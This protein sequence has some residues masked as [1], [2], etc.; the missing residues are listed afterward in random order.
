MT[1]QLWIQRPDLWSD[2]QEAT[3]IASTRTDVIGFAAG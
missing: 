2:N 3:S 1:D